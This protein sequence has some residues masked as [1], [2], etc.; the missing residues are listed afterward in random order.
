MSS[1][2]LSLV[3]NACVRGAGA[4]CELLFV[5]AVG[6]SL[7][8]QEAGVFFIAYTIFMIV[9][10]FSRC[11][12]DLVVV[13]DLPKAIARKKKEEVEK[14]VVSALTSSSAFAI[15]ATVILFSLNVSL[16]Y[17]GI[18]SEILSSLSY[19]IFS[20][21]P[22]TIVFICAE[23]FKGMGKISIS[24]LLYGW[25]L[26]IPPLIY[27]LIKSGQTASDLSAA[28]LISSLFVSSF[29]LLLLLCS[30]YKAF[31]F[32]PKRYHRPEIH[33]FN[34]TFWVRPIVL[35]ANW[36]PIWILGAFASTASA[37]Q[38]AIYNRIAAAITLGAIAVEAS[39]A[40]RFAREVVTKSVANRFKT[41][42][43]S[44]FL[45]FFASVILGLLLFVFSGQ[46]LAILS[47][48]DE[49]ND[50]RIL[51]VMIIAYIANGF[52]APTGTFGLMSGREG[53]VLGG[54]SV[55]LLFSL[56]LFTTSVVMWGA[57]GASV[58]L[59]IMFCLRGALFEFF[60][61]RKIR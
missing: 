26:L 3:Q 2:F 36:I 60:V 15:S 52:F 51:I 54:Y 30:F 22:V 27:L 1:N 56:G 29:C 16:S 10:S 41:L 23:V 43:K 18:S 20:I 35:L 47:V 45:S 39:Y 38:Y 48:G 32:F 8:F 53:V 58:A 61:L 44:Q 4:I 37:G 31:N 46:I 57:T 6:K 40:P 12:I 28:Y 34:Y 50:L 5:I 25:P 55:A 7:G 9:I 17:F 59:F 13:R 21:L 24:Q 14:I 49:A 11:G 42:R 19:F 33:V